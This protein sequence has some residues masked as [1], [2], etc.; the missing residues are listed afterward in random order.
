MLKDFQHVFCTDKFPESTS[1]AVPSTLG[2]DQAGTEMVSN[3]NTLRF[4][5]N[6]ENVPQDFGLSTVLFMDASQTEQY[7]VKL[8]T[9][10]HMSPTDCSRP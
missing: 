7:S 6:V 9:A 4:I 10:S 3:V 1:C 8:E 2:W 5:K